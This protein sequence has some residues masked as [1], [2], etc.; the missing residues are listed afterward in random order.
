MDVRLFSPAPKYVRLLKWLKAEI[1]TIHKSV[2][3]IV[4]FKSYTVAIL[5]K[6]YYIQHRLI[7]WKNFEMFF[8]ISP[9]ILIFVGRILL[10]S[11]EWNYMR[12]GSRAH[13]LG[14]KTVHKTLPGS[15]FVCLKL[16]LGQLFPARSLPN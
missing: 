6:K 7:F 13:G 3:R 8:G 9:S 4:L 1:K 12:L 10:L 14:T 5:T 2:V 11:I 16:D 15:L